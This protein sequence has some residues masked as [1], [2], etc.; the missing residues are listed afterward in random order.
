MGG[1]IFGGRCLMSKVGAGGGGGS[2]RCDV[3]VSGGSLV[4][5]E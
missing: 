2:G 4:W 5:R 3:S 1:F